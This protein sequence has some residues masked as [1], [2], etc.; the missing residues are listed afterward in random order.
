[1][2]QAS[3]HPGDD[4]ALARFRKLGIRRRIDLALHLPLRYEDHTRITPMAELG[5][6][7]GRTVQ[8]EGVVERAEVS[9]GGRRTLSVTLAD[10]NA[11][12]LLRFFNFYPSQI[13]QLA[14]GE[15]IRAIG[16]IR[17]SLFGVEIVHPRCRA[18]REDDSL[19]ARLTPVYPAA[20][21]I[22]QQ[23]IARAI[24]PVLATLDLPEL[25]SPAELERFD[26][27]D[28]TQAL[29][30]LHAPAPGS[31]LAALDE[32]RHPAW[33]RVLIDELMAQQIALA[34]ARARRAEQSAPSLT[35]QSLIRRLIG[36]LPFSLT[37]AQQ[38]VIDEIVADLG[39]STPMNRLLQGDVG[40]GKTVV[41]A[42]S[43]CVAVSSGAQVALMA[44]T[45]L[46]AQQHEARLAPWL[47][48]LGIRLCRLSGSLRD[49]SKREIREQVLAGEI[50]LVI[51]T[52]A[53]IEQG[54]EFASLG[55]SIVDEQHRFGV[56]QRLLL[57]SKNSELLAHQLMMS[58]TP[59]PRTLAMS[60]YA[61][62]DVSIIDELPPGR[63]PVRTRL[64]EEA[65]RDEVIERVCEAARAGRQ[66]Y[67]VCPLI[68]ES[69]ALDLQTALETHERLAA[70]LGPAQVG[71]VHG[72]LDA[73]SKQATMA[74][75]VSGELKVLVATTVIEVGVDVPTASLMV[76]EN[77]ERFGLAQLHQLR[78]RVGRGTQDSAC[79]LLYRNPLSEAARARLKAL[80]E[81]HD[82]FEIARRDLEIRGPG[83]FLGARQ[84]GVPLLRFADLER[85]AELLDFA[86]QRAH[87][88][89]GRPGAAL[90]SLMDRWF[91]GRAD[92]LRA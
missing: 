55:L 29:Q 9:R 12:L 62:L 40:S 16:E 83:E 85:D 28:L 33:R 31:D 88:L 67:W 19:P 15:R 77:A 46:L 74:G 52:H 86:R 56:A 47:E 25:L 11:R 81:T 24:A 26:L 72:R 13:R 63:Q 7:L 45:E 71:I 1:M 27:P 43:A 2:P 37:G 5:Q 79:V 75:F 57:R 78:G 38:T 69:E 39:L 64:I 92:Y 66:V 58:A 42:A 91:G 84:S 44:P 68:E 59:I 49:S 18:V 21:G 30:M 3:S 35:D 32:R 14:V 41:A 23:Q 54:C 48:P 36:S 73:T 61:D 65:R 70:L 87:Q 60:Y 82:G 17:G 34:Q 76:I 10:G 50:D 90:A 20:A 89:A 51:G 80:Y 6:A 53:L 4:P 22:G 8:V